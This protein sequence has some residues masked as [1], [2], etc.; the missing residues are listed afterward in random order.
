[1]FRGTNRPVGGTA[2]N[3]NQCKSTVNQVTN[4]LWSQEDVPSYMYLYT[5]YMYMLFESEVFE[6]ENDYTISMGNYMYMQLPEMLHYV[7][8]Y[9]MPNT[10]QVTI[11]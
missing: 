8:V 4:I 7:H 9:T 3:T 5:L 6:Q 11:I 2:V 1:M 10:L